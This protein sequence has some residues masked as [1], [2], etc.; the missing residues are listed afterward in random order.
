MKKV[1]QGFRP[2]KR[3]VNIYVDVWQVTEMETF[4]SVTWYNIYTL[5]LHT[6]SDFRLI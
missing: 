1:S 2:Q 6:A 3:I 4:E 5:Y